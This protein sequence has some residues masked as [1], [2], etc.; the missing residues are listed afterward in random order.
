MSDYQ[1][2]EDRHIGPSLSQESEML[3][4]LGY[5][6]LKKFIADVVPENIVIEKKL[7]QVLDSAKSE[8]EVIAELRAMADENEVFTSLIG[9]GYY[10]TITPPVVKRNVLEN[11]AWYTAYTPYQPEISQGRLEALFAFQTVVCEMTALAVS[12]ASMLDEGT[13]AAEAMT[14][15]RRNSKSDDSS[16]F[17]IDKNVHAQTKQPRLL[18]MCL[19]S[20][21]RTAKDCSTF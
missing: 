21:L 14:L 4:V 20:I 9:G 1:N 5:S 12:N 2:F 10:G 13:A 6:D 18:C 3:S 15:A 7:S 19:C 8:V 16:V 11:P 17:L